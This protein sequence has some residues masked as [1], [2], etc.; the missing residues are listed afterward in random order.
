MEI[1]REEYKKR[2]C[3]MRDDEIFLTVKGMIYQ[4]M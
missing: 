4:M 2:N 3:Y 1:N